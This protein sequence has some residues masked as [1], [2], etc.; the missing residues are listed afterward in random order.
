MAINKTLFFSRKAYWPL[1]LENSRALVFVLDSS[2]KGKFHEA[3]SE[4]ENLMKGE[5]CSHLPMLILG[6][7][8]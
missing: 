4:I 2:D 3:K 8:F 5:Y 1:Y 6:E 7:F